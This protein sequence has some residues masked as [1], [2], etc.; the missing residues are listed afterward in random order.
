MKFKNAKMTKV[1]FKNP[2]PNPV[3]GSDAAISF[4]PFVVKQNKGSGPQ[5][6]TS[7]MQIKKVPFKGVK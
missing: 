2:F 7:K 3:V 1:P 5:G 6:Q 4:A